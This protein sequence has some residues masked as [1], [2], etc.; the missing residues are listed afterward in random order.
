MK[1]NP[2]VFNQLTNEPFETQE[3]N[4][5]TVEF[6]YM[7]DTPFLFQFASRGRFAVWTSDGNNYKVLIESTYHDVMKDFYA[8]EVNTIWLGFLNNVSAISRKINMWF[9]IPTLVLYVVIAGLATLLFPEMMLQILLFMIVLVVVSN[10]VQG[11][12]VNRK[13]REENKN[14]QDRIRE[15]LGA[16]RFDELVAAQEQHYQD[17]FKF[18]EN[19]QTEDQ[20]NDQPDENNEKGEKDGTESN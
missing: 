2:K 11:R 18:D 5:K 9:V 12:M 17:Y 7:N 16:A 19:E 15:H 13:V 6:H 4:G 8:Q 20:T 10:M 3:V 14:A 1:L